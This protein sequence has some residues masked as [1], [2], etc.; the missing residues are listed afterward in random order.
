MNLNFLKNIKP[1]QR[2]FAMIKKSCEKNADVSSTR[3][4]S[5]IISAMIILFCFYFLGISIY[6]VVASATISIPNEMIIIF[7]SLLTHQ[8][9]LLGINKHNETKQK[10]AEKSTPVPPE[11]G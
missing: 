7:A 4:T 10:I 5:Y 9:A 8:L 3:I 1:F 11:V 2:V 6:I